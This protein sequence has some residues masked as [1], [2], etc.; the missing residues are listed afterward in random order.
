MKKRHG[1]QNVS[2]E[3]LCGEYEAVYRYVLTLCQNET[4]AQDITQETFLKAMKSS[5]CFAGDSSLYTWLC[6]I[7][8]NTWLDGCRKR[9]QEVSDDQLEVQAGASIPVEE[10]VAERDE[11]MRLHRL[12]HQLKEPY[13]EVFSLRVFGQLS[14]SEIASLFDK[15]ESWARV[16]YYRA[17]T[18]IGQK[19]GKDGLNE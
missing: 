16:T 13:K 17:K 18:W 4:E 2:Q 10:T 1:G 6:A 14:F 15:S 11:A 9:K 3:V 8:K 19:A 7:A 5:E 12:L